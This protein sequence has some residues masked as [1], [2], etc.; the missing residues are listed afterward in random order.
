VCTAF[1]GDVFDPLYYDVYGGFAAF[2]DDDAWDAAKSLRPFL[3]QLTMEQRIQ[4]GH[5]L[6]KMLIDCKYQHQRCS[7]A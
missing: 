3:D 5:K 2:E 6:N 1:Q 4:T 7:L